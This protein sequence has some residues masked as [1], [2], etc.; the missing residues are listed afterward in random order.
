MRIGQLA[1][2]SGLTAPTVRFYEREGLLPRPARGENGYREYTETDLDRARGF[3]QFRALGLEPPIAA[4]LADQCA[5]GQCETT[6]A[7]LPPLLADQR[8]AIAQ[9]I[10]ELSDLD[11]RPAALQA[12]TTTGRSTT[13]TPIQLKEMH[14][15]D[16]TCDDDGCC[17]PPGGPCC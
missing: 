7:E 4:R 2:Q 8:A 10:A 3:A 15:L 12:T 1:D 5:S 11:A 14:M 17:C 6:W 13:S 16:C 9:R